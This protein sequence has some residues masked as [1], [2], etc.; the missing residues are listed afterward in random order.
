M[1]EDASHISQIPPGFFELWFSAVNWWRI[2]LGFLLHLRRHC[3]RT[4]FGLWFHVA[5]RDAWLK[6]H[7]L[8]LRKMI[9]GL[10]NLN[11]RYYVGKILNSGVLWESKV[12]EFV[13]K[14]RCFHKC[15]CWWLL[16]NGII[17]NL[18]PTRY[19]FVP[20]LRENAVNGA[21]VMCYWYTEVRTEVAVVFGKI[22]LSSE[23]KFS[24]WPTKLICHCAWIRDSV[25]K[26]QLICYKCKCILKI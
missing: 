25:S 12:V 3:R 6:M 8:R 2:E 19:D 17:L 21:A 5:R 1:R 10:R 11:K 16:E 15:W 22:G 24:S 13:R 9:K 20:G 18:I 4:K 23:R 14:Q 26:I 7:K